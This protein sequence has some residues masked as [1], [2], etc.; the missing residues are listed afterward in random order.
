M[1]VLFKTEQN[2][3]IIKLRG[4]LDHHSTEQIRSGIQDAITQSQTKHLIFDFSELSF[5]DSAGI[6]MVIGRYKLM[7]ALGGRV[8]LVC[9]G[10]MRKIAEM[11]GLSRL[12]TICTNMEQA[13]L[14][15]VEGR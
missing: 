9:D 13:G 12:M 2:A 10:R 8:L 4:E 6:G 15:L 5:M 7:Q 11:S 14:A 1:Q 3:L